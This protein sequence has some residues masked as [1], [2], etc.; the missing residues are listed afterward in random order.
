M[1]C[2]TMNKQTILLVLILAGSVDATYLNESQTGYMNTLVSGRAPFAV[3]D[4]F[5][6]MMGGLFYALIFGAFTIAF[7]I[8]WDTIILPT[9]CLDYL[10]V[11]FGGY[12]PPEAAIA[13]YLINAIA[14]GNVLMKA[15][16]PTYTNG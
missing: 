13:I 6:D 8:K 1:P 7:W 3:R 2:N 12:F 9:L 10:L 5:T 11:V 4:V 16:S 15:L 14:I